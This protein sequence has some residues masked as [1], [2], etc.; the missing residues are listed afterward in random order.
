M[1]CFRPLK[2][3]YRRAVAE[4]GIPTLLAL[5]SKQ[6][7]ITTYKDARNKC[8]NSSNIEAGFEAT[9][10]WP[11]QPSRVLNELLQRE[12]PQQP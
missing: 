10:L 12:A 7:F 1:A 5:A 3:V 11:L 9:G 6:R 2:T 8:L 4:T